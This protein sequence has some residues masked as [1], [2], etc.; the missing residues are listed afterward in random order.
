[1]HC[2]SA[3]ANTYTLQVVGKAVKVGKDVKTIKVGDRVGVG[4]QIG[5]DLTCN[6]C[7]AD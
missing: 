3:N 5:A 4:A 7:K 1:M 2:R 6:N